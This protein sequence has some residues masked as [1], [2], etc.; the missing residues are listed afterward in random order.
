M[1][2]KLLKHPATTTANTYGAYYTPRGN[3][4]AERWASLQGV[5]QPPNMPHKYKC[6]YDENRGPFLGATYP[7]ELGPPATNRPWTPFVASVPNAYPGVLPLP[8]IMSADVAGL[9]VSTPP[10]FNFGG[11]SYAATI[12][13]KDV[14]LLPEYRG[15]AQND[16]RIAPA[17]M[18]KDGFVLDPFN[19]AGPLD[20]PKPLVR[21]QGFSDWAATAV[22]NSKAGRSMDVTFATGSPLAFVTFDANTDYGAFA[23]SNPDRARAWYPEGYETRARGGVIIEVS[24][25]DVV[26]DP[27]HPPLTVDIKVGKDNDH[28]SCPVNNGAKKLDLTKALQS[29]YQSSDLLR[30]GDVKPTDNPSV[31]FEFLLATK[32]RSITINASNATVSPNAAKQIVLNARTEDPHYVSP[33][34][35]A[36]VIG[37]TITS[38]YQWSD[39]VTVPKK[40]YY[41]S[42]ALIAPP[43]GKWVFD[44]FGNLACDFTK[45]DKAARTMIVCAMPS[46]GD[47]SYEHWQLGSSRLR[48]WWNDMRKYAYGCPRHFTNGKDDGTG[49]Q[50]G[51][52]QGKRFTPTVKS[53]QGRTTV[54]TE[55]SF[56][57]SY[58]AGRPTGAGGTLFGL[59]P[60]QWRGYA[61]N[62]ANTFGPRED[63]WIVYQTSLGALHL[64][65]CDDTPGKP[66]FTTTY[67]FP[68]IFPHLPNAGVFGTHPNRH[69]GLKGTEVFSVYDYNN[70]TG[71]QVL[72]KPLNDHMTRDSTTPVWSADQSAKPQ[73]DACIPV[74]PTRLQKDSVDSY[75]WGKL[76]G[77]LGDMIQ[78]ARDLNNSAAYKPAIQQLNAQLAQWLGGAL[79]DADEKTAFPPGVAPWQ[80]DTLKLQTFAGSNGLYSNQQF[81][82]YDQQWAALIPYPTSFD[83]E[84][85]I[86]DHHFH[87]GYW[88]RAA[89]QLALAQA[90]GIDADNKAGTFINNYGAAVNLIIKNLANPLRGDTTTVE[91]AD[92]RQFPGGPAMPFMRF[93]DG[94][95]G[96]SW[97]S[98]LRPNLMDQ[99]SVSEAMSA[100]TGV[101][102][103]AEV[104]N[105]KLMR[106]LGIWMYTHEMMS[107]YEYW[108]DCAQDRAKGSAYYPLGSEETVVG[109][110]YNEA[111]AGAAAHTGYS[112]FFCQVYNGMR[113][114]ATFFGY[115]PLHLAGIQWLPLH[116]GSLYLSSSD[117]AIQATMTRVWKWCYINSKFS[118]D[119]YNYDGGK[120][121]PLVSLR[122]GADAF[123]KDL[124]DSVNNND[125]KKHITQALRD[126]FMRIGYKL[127][128]ADDEAKNPVSRVVV[129]ADGPSTWS[130]VNIPKTYKA[131]Q[132]GP[133][134]DIYGK[135]DMYRPTMFV[136][137]WEPVAWGALAAVDPNCDQIYFDNNVYYGSPDQIWTELQKAVS[138]GDKSQPHKGWKPEPGQAASYAYYW[139]YT[140]CGL[141]VR[142][143]NVCA[144]YPFAMKLIGKR[145]F[146]QDTQRYDPVPITYVAWNMTGQAKTVTFSDGQK[147]ENV[148]PYKWA[149]K[150]IGL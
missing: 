41:A 54:T 3:T 108:M 92:A 140:A 19:E 137:G 104:T 10:V 82:L 64:A 59:F 122:Q 107:F 100:W 14:Q 20:P 32:D 133:V 119:N 103:W 93:V 111:M 27:A 36:S 74:P 21:L 58:P 55:F 17:T 71:G 65:R 134:L 80:R 68:G 73:V 9:K 25:A 105:D 38:E 135:F 124:K 88:L 94:Y 1:D 4:P 98:G 145:V 18:G 112:R 2:N 23:L 127:P 26:S 81:L 70:A 47:E 150:V 121:K 125:Q 56:N 42:Y 12:P 115:E 45:V 90:Q 91:K 33:P 46:M 83:A 49:T 102:L 69:V 63:P 28:R 35:D 132:N 57:L 84:T 6:P 123:V 110:G 106:D 79:V 15:D 120:G 61:N 62:T 97:A 89:A 48:M 128:T 116:G 78:P 149:S 86:N 75:N 7:A 24:G 99:E 144:D 52:N 95:S 131:V 109:Y 96:H 40:T 113:K 60:H 147:V 53:E 130:V 142:D 5:T 50:L 34:A 8:M 126:D 16:F 143:A 136:T 148:P 22:L 85:L 39:P 114:L 118:W 30:A 101:I 129:T 66:A 117:L 67:A 31:G 139:V 72:T 141:G 76:V 37:I 146:H 138:S 11:H 44:R 29:L 51:P 77:V 13:A 43:G 87:Y